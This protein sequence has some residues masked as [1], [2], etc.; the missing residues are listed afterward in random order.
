MTMR[1]RSSFFEN[2]YA[3]GPDSKLKE[4][5]DAAES[6]QHDFRA[7]DLIEKT[8]WGKSKVYAVIARAEELGCIAETETPRG[9]PLHAEFR[10]STVR[11]AGRD[12]LQFPIFHAYRRPGT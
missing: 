6:L 10:C 4:L 2:C 9:L 3:T 12:Q 11:A 5:L 8:G 1:P 7:S